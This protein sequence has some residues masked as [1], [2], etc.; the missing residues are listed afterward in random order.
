MTWGGTSAR[1]QINHAANRNGWKVENPAH[2]LTNFY[3]K[4]GRTVGVS[5]TFSGSVAEAFSNNLEVTG[6][7]PDVFA[8]VLD[9]L[10]A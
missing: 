8:R 1:D 3:F 4:P 10:Q 5:F 2:A 9:L 7:H 6:K